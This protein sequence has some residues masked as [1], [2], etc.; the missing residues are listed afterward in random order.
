MGSI[1]T[2]PKCRSMVQLVPESASAAG[3]VAVG[4][5]S[6]DSQ[7]LTE[8]AI[9]VPDEADLD[10]RAV[11]S[12]FAGPEALGSASDTDSLTSP[13]PPDWQSERTQRS[14]QIGMIVALSLASLLGAVL[15][16]GWF[17][18][19]WQ[20][21]TASNEAAE[22]AVDMAAPS[23]DNQPA[24]ER[25]G[26]DPESN[27]PQIDSADPPAEPTAATTVVDHPPADETQ[28]PA[29]ATEPPAVA[30]PKT[31]NPDD[32]IGLL[33]T[34]PLDDLDRANPV[35]EPNNDPDASQMER[36]PDDLRSKIAFLNLDGEQAKPTL[37]APPTLDEVKVDQASEENLNPMLVANPPE[38]INLRRALAIDFALAPDNGEY[39]LSDLMLTVSQI[40][41]VPIQIDWV[42]FDLVGINIRDGVTIPKGRISAKQLLDEV[43]QSI[44]AVIEEDQFMLTLTIGDAVKTER[45]AKVFDLTDFGDGRDSA[46]ATLKP[47][48]PEGGAAA[49]DGQRQEQ[50]LA[51]LAIEAMRRI[52]GVAPKVAEASFRRWGQPAS[53]PKLDWPLVEGGKAGPQYDAPLTMAGFLRRIAKANGATLF[54]NWHDANRRRM[55]PVQLTMPFTG[56]D[57][58]TVIANELRPFALQA[59]RVDDQHWWV[60]AEATYDRFPVVVWTEPL[61]ADQ[62]VFS[63][64]IANAVATTGSDIFRISI[65]PDSG[66]AL[67]LLPRFLVRQMP[68]IQ[69][70]LNLTKVP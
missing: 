33:P 11:P 40:T 4:S 26:V 44:G 34:S 29:A 21:E 37:Q 16:F 60:G 64:R 6:V 5:A 62:G 53:S 41:G 28:P 13:L 63:Q 19:S 32:L 54:V 20:R 18:R 50:Q 59:R 12:G 66:R 48:M 52:R 55:S 36:L 27:T 45:L 57:A 7:A 9:D 17:V 56:R 47:F 49:L 24:A 51:A 15:F 61:G 2:C 43:A 42:S 58:A 3:Q 39:P 22:N 46:A 38:P 14:R 69:N 67:L 70:G 10:P 1:A 30:A 68:K 23:Q 35:K 31:G 8:D 65:D 25:S